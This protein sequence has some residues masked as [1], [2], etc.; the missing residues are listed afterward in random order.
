[1]HCVK[2]CPS[3]RSNVHAVHAQLR[4]EVVMARLRAVAV[5]A[6]GLK[7]VVFAPLTSDGD[8]VESVWS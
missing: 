4:S 5:A 2:P 3:L 1:M 8:Q 7:T 6:E